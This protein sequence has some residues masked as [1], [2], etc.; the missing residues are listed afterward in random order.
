MNKKEIKEKN[1]FSATKIKIIVFLLFIIASVVLM[2]TSYARYTTSV[3]GN[4]KIRL[5][6]TTF[7]IIFDDGN[8]YIS[9]TNEGPMSDEDGLQNESYTFSVQNSSILDATS[10][11]YLSDMTSTIPN[12]YIKFAIKKGNGDYSSPMTLQ[13]LYDE[14]DGIIYEDDL[15]SGDIA[16]YTIVF[17]ISDQMPNSIN[18]ESL[19]NK[20]FRTK[21]TVETI[22]KVEEPEQNQNS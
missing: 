6:A 13:Y 7:D 10:K 22:Q 5:K 12:E 2:G 1:I 18:N 3:E 8:E 15:D 19:M 17:W 16:T 11:I 21:I 20:S 14:M 4:K 9:L